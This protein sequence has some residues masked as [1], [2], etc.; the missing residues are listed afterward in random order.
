MENLISK[1]I[2]FAGIYTI[3][4]GEL[5]LIQQY[6]ESIKNPQCKARLIEEAR[7]E[8]IKILG[9]TPENMNIVG[10]YGKGFV[11]DSAFGEIDSGS[12][13]TIENIEIPLYN[14]MSN[15]SYLVDGKT[16]DLRDAYYLG[17]LVKED[18]YNIREKYWNWDRHCRGY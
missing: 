2:D 15:I 4:Q 17:Y 16:Y 9:Y 3:N 5:E 14:S 11:I 7:A 8:V 6:I 18:L 1:G 10:K 12:Y 13:C